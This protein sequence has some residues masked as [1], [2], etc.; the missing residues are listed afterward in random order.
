M[1]IDRAFYE[2]L[3][4]SSLFIFEVMHLRKLVL[5]PF[6]CSPPDLNSVIYILAMHI[7]LQKMGPLGILRNPRDLGLTVFLGLMALHI[8]LVYISLAFIWDISGCLVSYLLE[9]PNTMDL[10]DYLYICRVAMAWTFLLGSI[11]LPDYRRLSANRY[12][13]MVEQE[14]DEYHD[15][16]NR[17]TFWDV[18]QSEV[19]LGSLGV[20][21]REPDPPTRQPS[22]NNLPRPDIHI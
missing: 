13:E 17:Y 19:M 18:V 11:V 6:G 16:S 8:L 1:S 2:T 10:T 15:N 20:H 7:Y 9:F 4:F 3:N 22:H 14:G 5:Q 12:L 21:Y